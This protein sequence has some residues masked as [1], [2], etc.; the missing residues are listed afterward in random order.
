MLCKEVQD[1]IA[2]AKGLPFFYVVGDADYASA[3]DELKQNGISVVRISDFC[4][5]DDKFPSIDELIDNFRTSDVDYRDN[6]FVV[7]GLGEFLAIK[8]SA[9]AD[10][11]LHRLKSTTL[12][13]ARV[14]LLL[15]G[16]PNQAVH[17]IE[18]DSRMEAQK[19]AHIVADTVTQAAILNTAPESGMV[20]NIGIKHLIRAFEDGACESV[21]TATSLDLSNS[22]LPVVS[23][24]DAYAILKATING[25]NLDKETGTNEQWSQLLKELKDVGNNMTTLFDKYGIDNGVSDNLHDAITGLE[26]KNW[27]AFVYCKWNQARISNSYLQYVVKKTLHFEDFKDNILTMIT[28]FPHTDTRYR[29][30]YDSRKRLVREFPDEDAAIFLKANEVDSEEA[31]YR[32]TD[33]TSY[34]RKAIVKWTAQHGISDALEYIYPALAAYLK[35]YTFTC[36]VLASELTAYMDAYKRQKVSNHLE[37][38]FVKT[39]EDYASRYLY[40]Q[41]PTRDSA[42]Q[43]IQDKK[44]AFL[45]WIDALGVEYLSYIEALAKKKGLSMRVDITR[46]DLPT[47]TEFNKQFFDNWTGGI[48]YKEKALDEIKHKEEGGYFF[49]NDEDPIHIPAE[50][51]VIEKAVNTAA[52]ELT[53]HRCQSFVIASDHGASRLAVINKKEIPY[54][55]DTKGEHSGRC[56][57]YFENCDVPFKVEENNH[58]VLS[59]YGRFKKSRS[60]NVEVHGGASLEEVVVPVI[61]L[62]LKK[63]AG[64]QI[65]VVQPDNIQL[66]RRKGVTLQLYISDTNSNKIS[67]LLND[68]RYI[69]ISNDSKHFTFAL[70]DIKRAKDYTVDVYDAEDLI[71]TIMFTVKGKTATV[72]DDFDS[73]F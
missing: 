4:F 31:I 48:K 60:A 71:G 38:D 65:Q 54:D 27:L 33:N 1:Y 61:T 17:L 10:K 19:R 46:C 14:I 40:A 43:A 12:G 52:I 23:L 5:K 49:T 26:F 24:F 53:M 56:C 44:N 7:V 9:Y 72:N 69:G 36:P 59:D 11:E 29:K 41:L 70:S 16:V 3:L 37:T 63:N 18:E 47:I 15:R 51:A 73:L 50:L 30:M 66:D 22:L 55:T 2:S 58:I 62:T 25:F 35:K 64:V 67:I 42:I 6:K 8:G 32:F 57:A 68:K 20:K 21:A 45:Y 39:V 34:E 28:T 13:S